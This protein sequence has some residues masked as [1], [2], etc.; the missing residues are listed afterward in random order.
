MS[1]LDALVSLL[2]PRARPDPGW[3]S[4]VFGC[5]PSEAETVIESVTRQ[6]S[7]VRRMCQKI[8]AT[9]RTYYAQFPAPLELFAFVKLLG[10]RIAVESGVGSGVSSSFMLM[11]LAANGRGTLY[12]IDMPVMRE[13]KRRGPSWAMPLGMSS[14]WAISSPLKL[15]WRLI[16]GSSEENLGPLLRKLG[17]ID[18]FC[19]DS[20]VSATHLEFEMNA[21]TGHLRRGS[22]VIAD[23]TDLNKRAFRAAAER[24]DATPIQRRRSRL[25]A[26]RVPP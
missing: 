12:S 16:L 18:F 13:S 22:I 8:V 15:R 20:P 9:G 24:F 21:I 17:G 2:G 4:E 25:A 23:N 14:G 10:P 11:G 19:H 26:F 5:T 3:V 7:Y 6:S 1:R